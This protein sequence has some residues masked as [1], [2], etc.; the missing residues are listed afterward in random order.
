MKTLRTVLITLITSSLF[1]LFFLTAIN[2]KSEAKVIQKTDSLPSFSVKENLQNQT[3]GQG[4]AMVR[5]HNY[6]DEFICSGT[7]I[8]NK[9]LLTAAHC[10]VDNEQFMLSDKYIIKILEGDVI[11][12]TTSARPAAVNHQTDYALM[13]GNFTGIR[14]YKIRLSNSLDYSIN[15]KTCG[16]PYGTSGVCYPVVSQFSTWEFKRIAYGTLFPGMSG[17]PVYDTVLKEVV[18][19]NSAVNGNAIIIAPLVGLFESFGI[20]VLNE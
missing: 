6:N 9:Y 2:H 14:T 18:G 17:G 20:E 5:I 1:Y 4:A 10:L 11:I 19:V 16:F 15:V 7:V 13:V 12:G 3:E 8:S